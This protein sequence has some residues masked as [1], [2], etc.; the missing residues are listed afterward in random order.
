[1]AKF[2]KKDTDE[3]SNTTLE[4]V[5]S[6]YACE[7]VGRVLVSLVDAPGPF[8][9]PLQC[10]PLK[11]AAAWAAL[12]LTAFRIYFRLSALRQ[13]SAHQSSSN[14]NQ[15]RIVSAERLMSFDPSHSDTCSR[16]VAFCI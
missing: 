11:P 10:D 12:S 5:R 3:D 2:L 4:R 9:T 6:I 7:F 13:I 14:T 8:A 1:M 15:Y 16:E